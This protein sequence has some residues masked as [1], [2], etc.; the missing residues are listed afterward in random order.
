MRQDSDCSSRQARQFA[1]STA[2]DATEEPRRSAEAT[3]RIRAAHEARQKC[4]AERHTLEER[5][6]FAAVKAGTDYERFVAAFTAQT[7]KAARRLGVT[8]CTHFERI[9]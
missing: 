1:T 8:L 6:N 7:Q 2:Q 3:A 9:V 5:G 4:R